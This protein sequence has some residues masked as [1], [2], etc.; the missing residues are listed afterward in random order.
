MGKRAR[1]DGKADHAHGELEEAFA[2]ERPRLFP[3]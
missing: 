1:V 3:A 2:R